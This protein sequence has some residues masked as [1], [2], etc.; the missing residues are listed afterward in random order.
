VWK[1]AL[2]VAAA[3][4]AL[5]AGSAAG[6]ASAAGVLPAGWTHAEINYSV[7]HVP[8]TLI[9]DRGVVVLAT[10]S[11]MTLREQDGSSVQIA[12]SSSTQVNVDGQ[13]GQL[14]AIR[15]GVVA[16]AQRIDGGA[17]TLVRVHVPARLAQGTRR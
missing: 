1:S 2:I 11:S 6:S 16:I 7:N 5:A 8:H 14:T 12:L 4:L 3:S 13:A 17:A 9:L 10:G 15:R